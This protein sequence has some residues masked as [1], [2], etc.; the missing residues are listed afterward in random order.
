[1]TVE[2][3]AALARWQAA[4]GGELVRIAVSRAE[5]IGSLLTWRPH[6]PVTQF[7]VTK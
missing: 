4:L 6:L 5:P 7:S 1:V 3:E 2:G